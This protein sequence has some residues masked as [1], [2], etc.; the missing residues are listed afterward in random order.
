[1]MIKRK[2]WPWYL[3]CF[4]LI[5]FIALLGMYVISKKSTMPSYIFHNHTIAI[6]LLLIGGLIGGKI[7]NTIKLPAVTGYILIG[8]IL[9]L[10]FLNLISQPMT[11]ELE[12]IKVAGLSVVALIIGGDLKF[13]KLKS[14][15]MG[16]IIITI[17]Q[18]LWAFALVTLTTALLF[19]YALSTAMILG[20][21]SSATAPAATITVLHEYKA[22][23]PL[24]DMLVAIVALDDAV[25]LILFSLT[26]AIVGLMTG[27]SHSFHFLHLIEP[28]WEIFGSVLI[29][30]VLGFIS[31][32]FL[33]W[34]KNKH[35][36]VVMI[37]GAAF[38]MSPFAMH[39]NLSPLLANMT[40]GF[41]LSNFSQKSLLFH[42]FE[43][44]EF[45]IFIAF[46]TLAG[47]ELNIKLLATE[48]AGVLVYIIARG[49]GKIIGVYSGGC[50][51]K[52]D[53]KIKKYLG[54]AMLPQAGVAIALVLQTSVYFPQ[55]APLIT[56]L[57]LGS[58]A[59]NEIIGPIGTK[60]AIT[61]AGEVGKMPSV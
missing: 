46:F 32:F 54:F 7:I 13:S 5:L 43:D 58:V 41:I 31:I 23:G 1:M 3:G 61:K 18:V 59:I 60:Y 4:L 53:K 33:K 52:T 35:E 29:G 17:V 11:K 48:W 45:P 6:G 37:L 19:D 34:V 26:T 50:I 57:V 9:G 27:A 55:I 12:F 2:D 20:A 28:L 44:I 49:I 30:A 8:I 39:M 24:T 47:T 16:V 38:L 21:I 56:S 36:I 10:S 22:H 51:A 42:H 25:C 14:L 15:G 40:F